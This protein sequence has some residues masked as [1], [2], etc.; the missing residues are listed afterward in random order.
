MSPSMAVDCK[1]TEAAQESP[2]WAGVSG[3]TRL[4]GT[5][6]VGQMRPAGHQRVLGPLKMP[7]AHNSLESRLTLPARPLLW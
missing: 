7:E 5:P 6:V 1:N 3:L 4:F 2:G